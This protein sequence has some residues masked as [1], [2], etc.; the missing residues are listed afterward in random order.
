MASAVKKLKDWVEEENEKA[1]RFNSSTYCTDENF[2]KSLLIKSRELEL[3]AD[4]AVEKLAESVRIGQ[5]IHTTK[6]E[7]L[8]KLVKHIEKQADKVHSKADYKE[9]QELK[10]HV[11][12]MPRNQDL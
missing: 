9:L 12:T 8:D 5:D 7:T 10:D 2:K 11:D 4:E 1:K 3:K 6:L